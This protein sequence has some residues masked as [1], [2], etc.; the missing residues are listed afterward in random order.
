[1]N[2]CCYTF[3]AEILHFDDLIYPWIFGRGKGKGKER[4]GK[5]RKGKGWEFLGVGK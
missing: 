3:I 1:M 4:K 2:A 5:E